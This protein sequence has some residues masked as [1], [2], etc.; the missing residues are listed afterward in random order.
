MLCVFD[1]KITYT[2]FIYNNY[3]KIFTINKGIDDEIVVMILQAD[4][5]RNNTHN[6]GR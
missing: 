1:T 5:K 2:I 4:I 3:V 6:P